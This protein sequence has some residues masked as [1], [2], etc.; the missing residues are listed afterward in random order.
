MFGRTI[1]ATT[2]LLAVAA[3]GGRHETV[4]VKVD[5]YKR[6]AP[7][8][9]GA[10]EVGVNPYMRNGQPYNGGVDHTALMA[11]EAK[12][13]N[14]KIIEGFWTFD[15]SGSQSAMIISEGLSNA[16]FE[17]VDVKTHGPTRYIMAKHP[18]EEIYG[19]VKVGLTYRVRPAT[20]DVKLSMRGS[21]DFSPELAD[22]LASEIREG[23]VAQIEGLKTP[24]RTP[25]ITPDGWY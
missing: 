21:A 15:Y 17:V 2:L 22:R 20:I 7:Y 3:C 12:K 16:G 24:V 18:L 9:G 11:E 5:P 13:A 1:V 25:E 23:I 19:N 8:S 6:E 10:G 4:Q 14:Y